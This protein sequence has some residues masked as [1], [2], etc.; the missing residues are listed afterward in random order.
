MYCVTVLYIPRG[1]KYTKPTLKT[2]NRNENLR[3]SS[4]KL[5]FSVPDSARSDIKEFWNE[6]WGKI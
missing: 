5:T 4:A 2:K 3:F 6:L 1:K